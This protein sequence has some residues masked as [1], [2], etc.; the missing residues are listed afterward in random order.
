MIK[1]AM[2]QRR[3]FNTLAMQCS[4]YNPYLE[5]NLTILYTEVKP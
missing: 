5:Q 4:I 2:L 3:I 1:N